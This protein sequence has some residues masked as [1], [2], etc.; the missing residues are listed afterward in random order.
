MLLIKNRRAHYDY[1]IQKTWIAGIVL[2]GY[3]VK[4]LRLKQGSLEG[5][6]VKIMGEEAW[7]I[8]A[9]INPY[10]QASLENY[11]PKQTRKLL[12][13]KKEIFQLIDLTNNKKLACVPFEFLLQGN[14][15]KLKIGAGKG[16]KEYEKRRKIKERDIKREMAREMKAKS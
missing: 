15:I 12:L 10:Q 8:N 9:R 3:E 1:D 7:L 11:D 16:K 2:A 6:Y 13:S 14:R 4:S 5:S